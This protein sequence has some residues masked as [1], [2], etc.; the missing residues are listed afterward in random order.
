MGFVR[1]DGLSA[2][3]EDFVADQLAVGRD[4]A[5]VGDAE[6]THALEDADDE[7]ETGEESERLPGETRR[8]Q[9]GWDDGQR[10]HERR[11]GPR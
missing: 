4:D 10:L 1:E 5:A 2:D 7:G 11:M 9:S 6:L 8:A 3:A